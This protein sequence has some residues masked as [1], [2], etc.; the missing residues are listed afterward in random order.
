[1][2]TFLLAA[3]CCIMSCP[4]FSQDMVFQGMAEGADLTLLSETKIMNRSISAIGCPVLNSQEIGDCT[5]AYIADY[6]KA[7]VRFPNIAAEHSLEAT[8]VV[9]FRIDTDGGV[10]QS[11]ISECKEEIY[12]EVIREVL[13]ELSFTPAV[14]SGRRISQDFKVAVDFS[15]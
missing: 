15:L 10:G 14:K 7:N 9:V 11:T 12:G 5:I 8:C 13:G 6:L 1:M 4:L 2:K 3:L